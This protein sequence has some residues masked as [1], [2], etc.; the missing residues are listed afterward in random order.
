MS[1]T[2]NNSKSIL[3]YFIKDVRKDKYLKINFSSFQEYVVCD[4][5][6]IATEDRYTFREI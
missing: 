3:Q 6:Y 2:N 1:V 4:Y 5:F